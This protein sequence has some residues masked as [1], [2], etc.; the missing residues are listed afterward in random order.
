M[1]IATQEAMKVKSNKPIIA[2]IAIRARR[3]NRAINPRRTNR[4]SQRRKKS[5]GRRLSS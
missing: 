5:Q 1:I 4:T 3:I 2:R